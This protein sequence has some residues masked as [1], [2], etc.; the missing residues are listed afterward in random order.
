MII[1]FCLKIVVFK[2]IIVL[3]I[4]DFLGVQVPMLWDEDYDRSWT[5]VVQLPKCHIICCWYSSVWM[6]YFSTYICVQCYIMFWR[7]LF[8]S[9]FN[10]KKNTLL[11][12]FRFLFTICSGNVAQVG[13]FRFLE[14]FHKFLDRVR[15]HH[16]FCKYDVMIKQITAESTLVLVLLTR[17]QSSAWWLR[18]MRT[19]RCWGRSGHCELWGHSGQSPG[20]RACGWVLT[21]DIRK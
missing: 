14:I 18:R 11:D 9:K 4:V 15:L 17:C 7:Y 20:G 12:K 10:V 6:D 3:I 5:T 21:C 13:G 19:W 1:I 2:E 8:R 16:R